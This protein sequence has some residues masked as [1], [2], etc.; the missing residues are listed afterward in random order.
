MNQSRPTDRILSM[1]QVCTIIGLSR[2]TVWREQRKGRFPKPIRL[3]PGRVG[4]P[5][6]AIEIWLAKRSEG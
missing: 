2:T 6:G 3:S 5:Q 1:R 4:W